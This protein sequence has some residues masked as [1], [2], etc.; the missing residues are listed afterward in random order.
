MAG[1]IF[2]KSTSRL[3]IVLVLRVV[4]FYHTP[5]DTATHHLVYYNYSALVYQAGVGDSIATNFGV[6]FTPFVTSYPSSTR[7]ILLR[8]LLP[9]LS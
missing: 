8:S 6:E 2:H 3:F 5:F 4:S 1:W 9:D 7:F